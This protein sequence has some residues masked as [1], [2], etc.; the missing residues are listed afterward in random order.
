MA[1]RAGNFA[2]YYVRL[3]LLCGLI[4]LLPT[5][6][7]GR[8]YPI[9]PVANSP[10]GIFTIFED[11]K[12]RLWLG[13]VDDVYCFDGVNFYSLRQYGFPREVPVFFA[14]DSDGGIWIATQGTDVNGGKQAGGVYRYQAGHVEKVIKGDGLSVVAIAPGVVIAATGT[15]QPVNPTYGDLHR[16]I[17]VNGRWTPR[18]MLPHM[19]DHMTMDHQGNVLFPCPGGW[20]EFQG[21][22]AA[23]WQEGDF[24]REVQQHAGDSLSQR[25]LRDRYGCV[26]NRSEAHGSYK[27]PGDAQPTTLPYTLSQQDGSVHIEEAADGSVFMLEPMILGRPGRFVAAGTNQ[28]PPGIDTA[29]VGRDGTIWIGT[30]NGLFRFPHPFQLAYAAFPPSQSASPGFIRRINDRVLWSIRD[31]LYLDPS[32]NNWVPIPGTDRFNQIADMLPLSG[33]RILVSAV[34]GVA[35]YSVNSGKLLASASTDQYSAGRLLQAGDGSIWMAGKGIRRVQFEGD[36]LVLTA[37]PVPQDVSTALAYDSSRDVLWAYVG[38]KLL[39]R[40]D[41]SWHSFAGNNALLSSGCNYLTVEPNGDLWFAYQKAGY[42][43]IA[44]PASNHP[45]IHNFA[46][47][48]ESAAG[49]N[50]VYFI[51][52]DKLNRIWME[53]QIL[54][55]ATPEQA[56]KGEWLGLDELEGGQELSI[57]DM[58]PDSDGS[59]WYVTNNGPTHF[60]PPDDFVANFPKPVVSVAGFAVNG[61]SP[62]LAD[63]MQDLP[64]RQEVVAELGSMQFDRRGALHYRYRLLPERTE[65]VATKETA[66]HLGR[67]SWGKHT[68]QVQAQM[69]TGPWSDVSEQTFEVLKP[70]WITW[71]ALAGYLVAGGGIFVGGRRWRRR[72]KERAAKAFPELAEWRLSALSPEL[73][74]LNGS[75][76]EGRFEI[77]RILARGGFATV[78]EGRDNLHGGRPCAIKIFRQELVDKDWM[79]RRFHQEVLALSKIQHPNVVRIYGSGTLPEGA[80]YLVME[81]IDG[82]TL[83][84]LLEIGKLTPTRVASYLRQAGDALDQIHA[85]GI[86]HR[87]LKP[88]NLMIRNDA[89]MDESLVLIDFSIAIVKDPDETLH[90]LSRA[91]GTI[92]YMAPEQAIGYAD[93]STDIYSL[94]KIVIEMLTGTRL[95]VLLPDASMDLPDRVRELLG[96]LPARLSSVSMELLSSALEFDP[97]RRPK[98]AGAFAEAI[99]GDLEAEKE[100]AG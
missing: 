63:A 70:V 32:E 65:W 36:R 90:G 56:R 31:V 17:R 62:Q 45:V 71:P 50:P 54:H 98:D 88:E 24:R 67:I 48:I 57:Q 80:F 94:A 60:S 91:A 28:L 6:C 77:G 85:R 19:V 15:E 39:F 34:S 92:Y 86:C 18:L 3:F 47:E 16:I 59:I 23:H 30:E 74:Q 58:L 21:E 76:I 38:N 20:C 42:A 64:R 49:P 11:N 78:A 95:S 84:E 2:E 33:N 25:V 75:L 27:C 13:T 53:D 44:E 4:L 51:A 69:S 9:L 1:S 43:Y 81:F 37:E 10:H 52:R 68:L 89:E 7:L 22:L 100:F 83:R 72:R 99:A 35:V 87:D 96:T 55:V 79:A 97:T 66:V 8:N 73:Q 40:R 41:G 29:M 82:V 14:E 5:N 46:D 26:W 93:S 12:S 61:S